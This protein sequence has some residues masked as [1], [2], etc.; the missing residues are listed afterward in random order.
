VIAAACETTK[1]IVDDVRDDFFAI[2]IDESRDISIKEQILVVLC[3][4]DKNG[5]V[6]ERFVGLVHVLNTSA[7]SL[8]LALESLFAKQFKPIKSAWTRIRWG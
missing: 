5:S 3:Y 8:K 4:A 6:I 2:L 1:I 7:I